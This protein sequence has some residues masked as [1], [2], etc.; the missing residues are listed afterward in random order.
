MFSFAYLAAL[1]GAIACLALL[2]HHYKFVWWHNRVLAA[3]TIVFGVTFFLAW[4][5]AGVTSGI[6]FPGD[7]PF[8]TGWLLLPGVPIEELFFL[9]LLMYQTLILWEAVKR[10][11]RA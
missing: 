11:R 2:D 6:F 3:R 9:T 8:D 5:V 7:S 4:D 1:L 10:W